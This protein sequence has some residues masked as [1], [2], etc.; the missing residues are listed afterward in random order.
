[1]TKPFS[2]AELLA[3]VRALMR[4]PRERAATEDGL[5][6]FG[7]LT[8]HVHAREVTRGGEPVDLTRTEFDLLEALSGSPRLAFSRPRLIERVWGADWFGDDHLVDVHISNLRRKLGD[9]PA[10]P[11]FVSTVRGVGYRMGSGS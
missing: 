11:R 1:V 9:D 8:V 7:D 10:A 2:A 4:R 5:R 3:R 6:R